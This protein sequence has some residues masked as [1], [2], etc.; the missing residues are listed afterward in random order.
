MSKIKIMCTS[1][2]CIEYAPERYRQMDIEIIRVHVFF[3]G[4]EYL[5]GLDLDPV[6][7]YEKLEK[8]ENPKNNLPKTGMPSPAEIKEHFD[9]LC[10]DGYDEAIVFCISSGLGGTFN[11][12]SLVAADY[13]DRVKIHVVDT[14]IT[15]FV[16]GLLAIK[17][18]E[19]VDKG[20]DSDRILR[21]VA[22]MMKTQQFIG[23]DG[24]LDYL[25]YNGRL[26]GGKAF[27]GQM[28]NICPVVHFN[29]EGECVALESVR[30]QKKALNRTCELVKGMIGDR[31]PEDYI[32]FHVFTGPSVLQQLLPIEEKHGLKTN[33]E[34][35]IMSPVSGSHN[36]PWL[37]GYGLLLL[38]RED[39]PLEV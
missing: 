1:T 10:E 13:A 16:E 24:K 3:E 28:L 34:P 36:G 4:K 2:G 19:M 11:E 8:L 31:A 18:K 37:A 22:W 33:H 15:S 27:M 7:F 35:V 17:A 26:K 38:R 32:L 5:E 21:E 14:K 29:R 23:I 9:K 39:E 6:D 30:T 25:I 12:V 20:Y